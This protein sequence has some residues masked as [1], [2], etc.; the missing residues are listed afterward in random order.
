[1]HDILNDIMVTTA[2]YNHR[3]CYQL[4]IVIEKY[5][6]E[7]NAVHRCSGVIIQF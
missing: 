2:Y 1:M 7:L 4:F 5:K 3:K 6:Y